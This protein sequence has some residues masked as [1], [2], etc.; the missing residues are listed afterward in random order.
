MLITAADDRHKNLPRLLLSVVMQLT[1]HRRVTLVTLVIV[2]ACSNEH[3]QSD[4]H[5]ESQYRQQH[6]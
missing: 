5:H 1:D 4:E 6:D 3:Q 2:T